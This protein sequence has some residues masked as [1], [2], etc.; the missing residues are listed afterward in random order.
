MA[1]SLA[2]SKRASSPALAPPSS[3]P[4]AAIARSRTATRLD[5]ARRLVDRSAIAHGLKASGFLRRMLNALD[6]SLADGALAPS[7]NVELGDGATG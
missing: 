7:A 1:F 4:N 2:R 3:G 6:L 5:A